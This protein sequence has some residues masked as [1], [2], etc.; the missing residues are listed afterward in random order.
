MC[1]IFLW[2]ND[3]LVCL[4]NK[5]GTEKQLGNIHIHIGT[6]VGGVGNVNSIMLF[7]VLHSIKDPTG[8]GEHI[9]HVPLLSLQIT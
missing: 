1:C 9:Q 2:E 3:L 5:I 6:R 4:P 8:N 7:L